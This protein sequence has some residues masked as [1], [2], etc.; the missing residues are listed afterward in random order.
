M[1]RLFHVQNAPWATQF[2]LRKFNINARDDIVGLDFDR[3]L[4]HKRPEKKGRKIPMSGKTWQTQH[5]P[6]RGVSKTAFGVDY[7]K[8]YRAPDP[9]ERDAI[10]IKGK[11]MELNCFD[12]DDEDRNA[13]DVYVQRLG[14]PLLTAPLHT[15]LTGII[16]LLCAAQGGSFRSRSRYP[17]SI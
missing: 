5:D 17:K 13:W 1:L 7:L 3:Y 10:G 12:R 16:E 11:I 8:P 4:H 6:W 9:A 2:L 15:V 14:G